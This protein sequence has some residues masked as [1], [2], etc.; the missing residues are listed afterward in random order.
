M[1]SRL[2]SCDSRHA[3]PPPPPPPPP[4]ACSFLLFRPASV[5]Y[6]QRKL[7]NRNTGVGLG[8]RLGF[9]L[10]RHKT[11]H[12]MQQYCQI[13]SPSRGGSMHVWAQLCLASPWGVNTAPNNHCSSH[14]LKYILLRCMQLQQHAPCSV[15]ALTPTH[16]HITR[17][18][19]SANNFRMGGWGSC[20]MPD[21]IVQL[22]FRM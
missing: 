11:Q 20:L 12:C 6:C 1:E 21:A 5:Y 2:A 15:Q 17:M 13:E 16:P 4:F 19:S 14:R 7:K 18:Y 3:Y 10:Q 8:T 22:Q 9:Y